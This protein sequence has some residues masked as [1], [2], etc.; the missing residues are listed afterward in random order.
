MRGVSTAD[1]LVRRSGS[2]SASNSISERH[3][4]HSSHRNSDN[5]VHR[6]DHSHRNSDNSNHI[7]TAT[8]LQLPTV[9]THAQ[10]DVPVN[11]TH[12]NL[13]Y[14]SSAIQNSEFRAR[15]NDCHDIDVDES[16][17]FFGVYDGHGGDA[18][19]LWCKAK[20]RP[21]IYAA[22]GAVHERPVG[23]RPR[24]SMY[25]RAMSVSQSVVT[26]TNSSRAN[27][28]TNF[29]SSSNSSNLQIPNSNSNNSTPS[30]PRYYTPDLSLRISAAFYKLNEWIVSR[31]GYS[32]GG[33][34]ATVAYIEHTRRESLAQ[35]SNTH[36]GG[37]ITRL[38]VA[39]VGDVVCVLSHKGR[40]QRMTADHTLSSSSERERIVASGGLITHKKVDGL[41][42]VTRSLGDKSFKRYISSRPFVSDTVLGAADEFLILASNGLWDVVDDQTCVDLIRHI[43]DCKVASDTLVSYALKHGAADNIT[44]VVVRFVS[45]DMCREY[46]QLGETAS[47]VSSEGETRRLLSTRR[48]FSQS[49]YIPGPGLA[50]LNESKRVHDRVSRFNM[51]STLTRTHDAIFDNKENYDVIMAAAEVSLKLRGRVGPLASS[52]SERMAERMSSDRMNSIVSMGTVSSCSPR[53]SLTYSDD[54]STTPATSM[55]KRPSI[56]SSSSSGSSFNRRSQYMRS[57]SQV[58]GIATFEQLEELEELD[59]LRSVNYSCL[60]QPGDLRAITDTESAIEEDEDE[61]LEEGDTQLELPRSKKVLFA[62]STRSQRSS[63]STLELGRTHSIAS[64]VS[65]SATIDDDCVAERFTTMLNNSRPA[66][67]MSRALESISF[68]PRRASF[69]KEE[70]DFE[71][72]NSSNSPSYTPSGTPSA[73]FI[74]LQRELRDKA[75]VASHHLTGAASAASGLRHSHISGF[76][77]EH[78]HSHK[79]SNSVAIPSPDKGDSGSNSREGSKERSFSVQLGNAPHH[80]S[81]LLHGSKTRLS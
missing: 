57:R 69:E 10:P 3:G 60:A 81:H 39:N 21:L 44:V 40:A 4:S 11:H 36:D 62:S 46:P 59:R 70:R 12:L 7:T 47:I 38:V 20:L 67:K 16:R 53:S 13:S 33:G 74:S 61:V 66:R 24:T 30:P 72:S 8:K 55:A 29:N 43:D 35:S 77:P 6:N 27:N 5:S 48:A 41:H 15:M 23:N 26:D 2:T 52:S 73:S 31:S 54:E 9:S 79:K 68:E 80:I 58:S 45:S 28:A 19:A 42:R 22:L 18:T 56:S 64:T 75:H 14:A 78:H 71:G 76:F 25:A 37:M 50:T 65:S 32:L 51:F 63:A 49:G 1:I 34:C 17:A